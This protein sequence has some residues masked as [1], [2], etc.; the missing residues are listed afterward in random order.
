MAVSAFP[1]MTRFFPSIV[2]PEDGG[3]GSG[4]IVIDF[5][6]A[7]R[8]DL[9]KSLTIPLL[10]KTDGLEVLQYAMHDSS[11]SAFKMPEEYNSWFSSCFGYDV[12]LAYLGKN[13]RDVLFE[14]LKPQKS[15]SWLSSLS[16]MVPSWTASESPKITFAD[17]APF[18]VVS[19]TSLGDVSSR[20]PE[21]QEMDITKFRPN[22]VI[23]GAESAWEEDFWGKIDVN[24]IEFALLHNCVRCKSINIDY[25]TGQPGTGESGAVLKKMQKDRR[26]DTGAKWSPVF[27]RYTFWASKEQART[28]RVGDEVSVT[29]TNAERTTWT[30]KGFG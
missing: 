20:L 30:W 18:L 27:G 21:G 6:P 25:S 24:G 4:S 23:E 26:V 7:G 22:I 9:S 13:L 11:T 8:E 10:P 14:D 29:Q 2:L 3:S 28:L 5:K 15:G 12:V 1:G 19:K 16:S 17:C